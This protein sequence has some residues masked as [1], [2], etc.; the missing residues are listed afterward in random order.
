VTNFV[1]DLKVRA[2]SASWHS[3]IEFLAYTREPGAS[4]RR[5]LADLVFEDVGEGEAMKGSSFILTNDNAQTLI[6]DLWQ[7]G[8]RPTEGTGSAGA[9]RAVERHLDDYRKLVE[10]ILPKVLKA[11]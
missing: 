3:G 11:E 8:L 7:A 10:K 9:L 2:Q 4:T 1:E 5:V 6:D